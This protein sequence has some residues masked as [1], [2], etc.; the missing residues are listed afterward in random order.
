MHDNHAYPVWHKISGETVSC[1]EKIKVM[2]Q[3]LDELQQ[4]AQDAF[5]DGILMEID[6]QQLQN[7]LIKLMQQ[8][9]NP[10]KVGTYNV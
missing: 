6:P 4:I 5:E 3:N 10:Y 1:I 8:L 2:Q 7:Y 9:T